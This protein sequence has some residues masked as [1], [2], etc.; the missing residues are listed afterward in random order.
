MKNVLYNRAEKIQ[1]VILNIIFFS[2]LAALGVKF[3]ASWL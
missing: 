2:L 3:L 1:G